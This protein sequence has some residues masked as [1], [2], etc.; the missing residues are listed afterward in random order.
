VT[1]WEDHSE[2]ADRMWTPFFGETITNVR[3]F[4]ER[5]FPY[6]LRH[7]QLRPRQLIVL[8]NAIAKRALQEGTFPHFTAAQ[9][10][11]G[12]K[13]GER[14]LAKEVLNSYAT[15][16]PDIGHI[17]EA[18]SASPVMFPGKELDKRAPF[19]ASAWRE[20][21]YSALRFTQLVAE[22]GIVGRVRRY[23]PRSGFVEADFEYA[24]ED[25]L[26][27][28]T[29]SQCVIHPMFFAKLHTKVEPAVRVYPFPDH[30]HFHELG[31]L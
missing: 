2:V 4:E 12:V 16:Y 14:E 17:V 9:I 18:L 31:Q 15:V 30:P 8:C 5:T 24:M 1:D 13:Q 20:K 10:C 27:L 19:T 3:G 6:I 28:L 21:K 7:T 23:D 11:E 25:R 29:D 26:P 22:L